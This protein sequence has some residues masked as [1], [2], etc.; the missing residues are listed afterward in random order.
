MRFPEKED[1]VSMSRDTRLLYV[2]NDPV[3][4]SMMTSVLEG[5]TGIELVASVSSSVEALEIDAPLDVALLDWALGPESLN[6]VELGHALRKRDDDIGIVILSQHYAW[7]F[8]GA[9]GRVDMGWS[10]VEKRVNLDTE[11]LTKVIKATATGLSVVEPSMERGRAPESAE[12]LGM[13]TPRQ[14]QIMSI[15]ATGVDANVIA[16]RLNIRPVSVRKELSECYRVLVPDAAPGTDLRTA[17]VIAWIDGKRMTT[18]DPYD[19]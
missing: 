13:L 9:S 17:A 18:M 11:Y 2:E 5:L 8:H 15:A 7:D 3:L 16:E 1:D 19:R 6:G 14:R 12:R 4:R 10:Y